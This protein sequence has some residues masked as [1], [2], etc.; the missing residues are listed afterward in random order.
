MN[1]V[2]RAL[3][4][5]SQRL[6][7]RADRAEAL[8]LRA[9][10]CVVALVFC[11]AGAAC[12]REQR[13]FREAP[14]AVTTHDVVLSDLHPGGGSP[15][16]PVHTRTRTTQQPSATA[17]SCS[18]RTTASAAMRTA[19]AAS[20]RRCAT[21]NGA[22][23]TRPIRFITAFSRGGRMACRPSAERSPTIRFGSSLPTCDR[24]AGCCRKMS[25][26]IA[27]IT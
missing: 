2:S 10:S 24:L 22:T 16:T 23:A 5:P 3:S 19:G 15:T 1:T 12:K 26:R 8:T 27:T 21:T 6:P 13:E 20:A 9:T 14:P 17:S 18:A 7:M 25:P 4:G 11:V